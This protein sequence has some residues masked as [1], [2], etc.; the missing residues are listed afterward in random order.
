MDFLKV[1]KIDF[2]KSSE[3][4]IILKVRKMHYFFKL[5]IYISNEKES[6]SILLFL[7]SL[8]IK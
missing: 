7:I 4:E 2:F 1:R 3:N 5:L 8:N 6:I